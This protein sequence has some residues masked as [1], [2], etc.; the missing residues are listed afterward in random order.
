MLRHASK[1]VTLAIVAAVAVGCGSSGRTN[2]ADS[3]GAGA[4]PGKGGNLVVNSAVAPTSLDPSVTCQ[5]PETGMIGNFYARLTQAPEK[6]GEGEGVTQWEPDASKVKPWLATGWEVSPDGKIYTFKLRDGMRFPSG[7]PVDA[8]A[9][10][11]T[12]ERLIKMNQCGLYFVLSGQYEPR[13]IRRV[14]AVD[15]TT[16]RFELSTKETSFPALLALPAAGIVDPS[17]VEAHGGVK[18]DKVNEYMASHVAGYGPFTLRDYKPNTRMV[19]EA[20]PDFVE[21]PRAELIVMN[22]VKDNSTMVLQA[23]SGEADVSMYMQKQSIRQLADDACCRVVANDQN[24]YEIVSL[25]WKLEPLDDVRVREALIRAIPYAAIR[26]K[27]AFGYATPYWGQWLPASSWFDKVGGAPLEQDLAAAKRLMAEAGVKTPVNLDLQVL[28]GNATE[29]QLATVVQDAWKELGV[30]VNIEKISE[31]KFFEE[32]YAKKKDALTIINDGPAVVTPQFFV[33][34]DATCPA[35][36]NTS[37]VCVNELDKIAAGFPA[38]EDEAERATQTKAFNEIWKR[39]WPRVNLY[40]DKFA[41]V[42][43]R[44]VKTYHFDQLTD[45]RKWGK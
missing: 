30:R 18:K 13:L 37:D 7:K 25:P 3:G 11:Y 41:A 35:P 1:A 40:Q 29:E 32:I 34:Y 19:L 8:E 44:D 16:V 9:V 28:Q 2:Q 39:N 6:P 14:E 17:V 38:I 23:R 15:P 43:G 36:Y 26:D 12:I 10:K 24:L 20:N 42:L 22:F 4:G 33:N 45:M 21:P 31:S 5:L 27:V